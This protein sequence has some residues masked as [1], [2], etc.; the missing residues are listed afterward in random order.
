MLY[1][2]ITGSH[3][4]SPGVYCKGISLS[5]TAQVEFEPGTYI[6]D[7]GSLSTTGNSASMAGEGVTFY[8][9]GGGSLD[10]SGQGSVDLSAPDSGDLKG[11]V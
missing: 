11:I 2:V 9:T 6:I 7:G 4:L 3:T 10:L 5:S 8:F 1:E